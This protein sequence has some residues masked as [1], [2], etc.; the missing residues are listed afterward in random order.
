MTFDDSTNSIAWGCYTSPFR[1]ACTVIAPVPLGYW[2]HL[3]GGGDV[4]GLV[5][6]LAFSTVEAHPLADKGIAENQSK[7]QLANMEKNVGSVLLVYAK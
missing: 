4:Q 6:T 7:V 3:D 1:F 5:T 2:Y